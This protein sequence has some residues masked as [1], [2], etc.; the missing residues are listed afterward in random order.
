MDFMEGARRCLSF[1]DWQ[2]SVEL[3]NDFWDCLQSIAE[4]QGISVDK[5]VYDVGYDFAAED[6]AATLR[7]F[8]LTQFQGG[9]FPSLEMVD[10]GRVENRSITGLTFRQKYH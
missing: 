3:E 2:A 9:D 10:E 6:L 4:Q 7:V 5:L 8:V 1:G